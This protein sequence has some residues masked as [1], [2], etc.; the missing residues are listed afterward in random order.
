MDVESLPAQYW[1]LLKKYWLPLALFSVGMIFFIY[2]LISFFG[3][4][5]KSQTVTFKSDSTTVSS[6]KF[7]DLI[8]VDIEGAVVMPGVYKLSSG[9]IVQDVLVSSGGLSV[10]A[11][12][13]YVSKN[14]NLAAKLYD[15]A[16]I[17][18]PKT[19]DNATVVQSS[20]ATGQQVLINVNTASVDALDALPGVGVATATKIIDNR[21]YA[22]P[23][24]LLDKKV[25]SAKV[26]DQ[27][28]DR[29]SVY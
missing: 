16:K 23:N 12:R 11:D 7:Q 1:L 8:Q 26:F 6:P 29:I 13:N 25:V 21:P 4:A 2:G 9:A 5:S 22:K 20:G 10:D 24:D 3:L 28:K 27:I 18:I 15:G 19:G 17:Y 14:I